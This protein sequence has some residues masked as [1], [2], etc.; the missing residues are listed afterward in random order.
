M[1]VIGTGTIDDPYVVT[2]Y[3]ELVNTASASDVYI[4]I[5]N[6][7]NITD[8]YPNGNMPALA[9]RGY[10]DGNNKVIS[11]WY[12]SS[13]YAKS[14]IQFFSGYIKDL[15]IRN[16]YHQG[17][18]NS[19]AFWNSASTDYSFR[20]CKISGILINTRFIGGNYSEGT[21]KR[22]LGCSLNL[23]LKQSI[24][25]SIRSQGEGRLFDNCYCKIKAENSPEIITNT[26]T[27][28]LR[29]GSNSYWEIESSDAI[30]NNSN[31]IVFDNCVLDVTT[32]A[33]FT[34]NIN[35]SSVAPS[36]INTTKAPNCTPQNKLL[37]VDDEHWL[38]TAYLN[39]IG[40]NAG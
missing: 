22:C 33:T 10:I 28:A 6:D 12:V 3:A 25:V 30:I 14:A 16:I 24:F 29:M 37:G 23:L 36:I 5:G 32:N 35:N 26:N 38:D 7:I 9:I 8:E 2:T 18:S 13:T 21:G 20:N 34:F 19:F 31:Y 11:N 27:Y 4:K 40:F 39:S 17:G 15:E 1:A